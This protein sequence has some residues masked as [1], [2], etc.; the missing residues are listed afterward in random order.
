VGYSPRAGQKG[1]GCPC[2]TGGT[3]FA[4]AVLGQQKHPL[5]PRML[6]YWKEEV[7]GS[8]G[9]HGSVAMGLLGSAL[10]ARQAGG[11]DWKAFEDTFFPKI[12]ANG[13]TDGSFKHLAGTKPQSLGNADPQVGPAYN[14]AVFALVLQLGKGN[15]KFLGRKHD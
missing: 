11:E 2:R 1:F 6:V 5:Y 8:D 15:L 12:L 9:G 4:F 3:I 14:T 7:G 13:F 10:A